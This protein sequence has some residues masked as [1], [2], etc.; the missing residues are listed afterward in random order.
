MSEGGAGGWFL[1]GPED[2]D[3]S[4]CPLIAKREY[5]CGYR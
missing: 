5:G 3:V 2:L 4:Q 1:R